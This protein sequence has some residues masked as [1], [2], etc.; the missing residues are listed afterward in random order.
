M[1]G[2]TVVRIMLLIRLIQTKIVFLLVIWVTQKSAVVTIPAT[3]KVNGENVPVTEI[4]ENAFKGNTTV[5][6]VK[7]GGNVTTIGEGAFQ[8]CTKLS[9]V[10]L[11]SKLKKIGKSSFK[12]SGLKNIKIPK[13]VKSIGTAAFKNCK[14]LKK[15]TI[16]GAPKTKKRWVA[17]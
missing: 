12:G 3:V 11:P 4:E 6:K 10:E 1:G 17:I 16:G 5:K 15:A 9:T 2:E 8:G 7:L 13:S 14:K